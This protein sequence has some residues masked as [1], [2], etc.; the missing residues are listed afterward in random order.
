MTDTA[1]AIIAYTFL[2]FAFVCEGLSHGWRWRESFTPSNEE[3]KRLNKYWHKANVLFIGCFTLGIYLIQ[4]GSDYS[5]KYRFDRYFLYDIGFTIVYVILVR[6]VL[7]AP[8][9][10]LAK[11]EAL[12]YIG[13][14]AWGDRMYRK[15]IM[16]Y[17]PP[18]FIA[19]VRFMLFAVLFANI[20]G[21]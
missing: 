21:L 1:I 8:V 16:K 9:N 6:W 14:T 12:N 15:Y 3:A 18:I 17:F 11:G 10:N 13:S 4:L 2:S 19:I 20:S 5:W 7:F